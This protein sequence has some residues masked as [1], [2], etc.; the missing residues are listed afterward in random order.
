[1]G[2]LR[3]KSALRNHDVYNIQDLAVKYSTLVDRISGE[4]VDA[5]G[6]HYDAIIRRDA[7]EDIIV[8][9]VGQETGERTPEPIVQAAIDSLRS[10]RHHYTATSGEEQLRAA[11][12]EHHYAITGQFVDKEQCSVFVGAQ[13]GLFA[14][15]QC[16]LE[17]GDDVLLLE[18]YYTTYPATFTATGAGLTSVETKSENSFQPDPD[19]VIAAITPN[20]RAIVI[21]S[22]NNPTGAI[23]TRDR[24]KPIVQACVDRDI[25]VICDEVYAT[26]TQ[27]GE[28]TSPCVLSGAD[29]VCI[30]VSSLSKSHRMTG[31]RMGWVVGPKRLSGHLYNLSMCMSYGLPPFIQDAAV[32][33]LR[34]ERKI[35]ATVHETMQRRAK[36]FLSALDG[37]SGVIVHSAVGGM[38]VVLDISALNVSGEKFAQGFLTQHNVSV[39]PCDGFGPSAAGLLRV[40]LCEPTERLLIASQRLRQYVEQNGWIV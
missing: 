29:K 11:I 7:G 6:V 32:V 35:A 4:S 30:S 36:S 40:S 24:L 16:L 13:N 38:F 3:Y 27:L 5:W 25:W 8:L 21:N 14:V 18:P 17:G 1:M 20:T 9:S 26:L 15:A 19:D 37:I 28:F 33:A 2:D 22:P 31:W 39:L 23:Y 34:T 12:A 10:G